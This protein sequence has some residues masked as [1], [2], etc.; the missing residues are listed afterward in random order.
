MQGNKLSTTCLGS[1]M[2]ISRR[3]PTFFYYLFIVY[4]VFVVLSTFHFLYSGNAYPSQKHPIFWPP[5][6]V[7]VLMYHFLT[8]ADDNRAHMSWYYFYS[9]Q[10]SNLIERR[11]K[12]LAE[13]SDKQRR[14]NSYRYFSRHNWNYFWEKNTDASCV[15]EMDYDF[16]INAWN[17]ETNKVCQTIL[18]EIFALSEIPLNN[19]TTNDSELK[20]AYFGLISI[21]RAKDWGAVD[22]YIEQYCGT[23]QEACQHISRIVREELRCIK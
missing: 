2:I 11:M 9:L 18:A 16:F 10:R 21:L 8:S 15:A 7:G 4:F 12:N 17:H 13:S 6:T 14:I 22:K 19:L 20:E 3:M 23:T 5:R 1:N